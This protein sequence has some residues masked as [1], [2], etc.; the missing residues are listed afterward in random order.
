MILCNTTVL[1]RLTS[2]LQ[3]SACIPKSSTFFIN[4]FNFVLI[5]SI[6]TFTI[7]SPSIA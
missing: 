4:E 6:A 1:A 7:S 2:R 3:L 5:S